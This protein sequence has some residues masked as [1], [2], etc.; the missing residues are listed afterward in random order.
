MVVAISIVCNDWPNFRFQQCMFHWNGQNT[1]FRE[2]ILI[3]LVY[4]L[5]LLFHVQYYKSNHRTPNWDR[6]SYFYLNLNAT[7]MS[8]MQLIYT[9]DLIFIMMKH[10]IPF[11]WFRSTNQFVAYTSSTEI[12]SVQFRTYI[13]DKGNVEKNCTPSGLVN[14]VVLDMIWVKHW[15]YKSLITFKSLS[16]EMWKLHD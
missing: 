3:Q 8:H 16:L 13:C 14:E 1:T 5:F 4:Q 15:E 6:Y 2:L 10:I 7:D 11:K 9:F 12:P